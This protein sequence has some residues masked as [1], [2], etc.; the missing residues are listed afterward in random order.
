MSME[1]N[2]SCR[3]GMNNLLL[4]SWIKVGEEELFLTGR[5]ELEGHTVGRT[6]EA[7]EA[8]VGLTEH[9]DRKASMWAWHL[10]RSPLFSSR[11]LRSA[12]TSHAAATFFSSLPL[13]MLLLVPSIAAATA[14]SQPRSTDQKEQSVPIL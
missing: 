2:L 3:K 7:E 10:A 9:E 11:H 12:S 6:L 13:P 5:E 8:A 4:H 1:I 14:T